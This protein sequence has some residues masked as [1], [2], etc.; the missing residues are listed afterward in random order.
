VKRMIARIACARFLIG[1]ALVATV[2]VACHPGDILTVDPPL[3]VQ[4][5]TAFVSAEGAQAFYAGAKADMFSGVS[6]ANQLIHLSGL[7]SDEYA[8]TN[9]WGRSAITNVDARST[10]AAAYNFSGNDQETT[11]SALLG[12]RSE[13]LIA[14]AGMARYEAAVGTRKLGEAFA[15]IGYIE[16][17]LAENYCAGVPLSH[18]LPTGGLEYGTPL[19]TDSLLKTA[20][21]HFDS[22]SAHAGGDTTVTMLASVGRGRVR[23]DRGHYDEAA[24]AVSNVSTAF[25]YNSELQPSYADG[26]PYAFNLYAAQT[27][28]CG[29][30]NVT[31]REG[32]NGLNY[33]SARDPRL[34]LDSTIKQTC[35][36]LYNIPT[37]SPWYYPVKFGN[38]SRWIPL[39]TGVEARLIEAEVALHGGQLS[40]WSADLN[41]LRANAAETYLQLSGAMPALTSDSTTGA[42]ADMQVDVMFRERAFW[43]FGTGTRLSD[44]RRL[45]RQYGR[46]PETV[47][48]TGTYPWGTLPDL[49]APLPSYGTD[50]TL[51]LPLPTVSQTTNTHYQGC[52]TSPGTA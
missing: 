17:M 32:G 24:S 20:E 51:T 52:L 18:V 47:F 33:R 12:A 13:L 50:V 29:I 23:L 42:S 37:S 10:A 27:L 8:Q 35:D 26:S 2:A 41:L 14:E 28:G 46:N 31:D 6:G 3:G 49:Q 7:L 38:P 36:E 22:A 43:L 21:S 4:A 25:V 16:L 40:A 30:V 44:M 19:T 15:L 48:P 5:A 9:V 45:I 39:A 34:V 1:A 11:V